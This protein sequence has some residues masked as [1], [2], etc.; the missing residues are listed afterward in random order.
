MTIS[1][2]TYILLKNVD[3]IPHM[4]DLKQLKRTRTSSLRY[5]SQA[6]TFKCR[7]RIR[8]VDV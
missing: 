5:A 4:G 2:G 6:V 3:L 7:S 8:I 1:N